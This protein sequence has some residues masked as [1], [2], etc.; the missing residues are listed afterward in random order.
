MAQPTYE[1]SGVCYTATSGQTTFAL[2]STDGHPIG[3]LS[4]N[5]IHIRTSA[6]SGETW[7]ILPVNTGWTFADPA[8]SIVLVTPATAGE[9]IDIRRKTPIDED[10]VDFQAGSL[11]TAGQLNDAETFSLYC[12][13]ELADDVHN[14]TPPEVGL[15]TTDDLPEGEVNLYYTDERVAEYIAE[16]PSGLGVTKII[17]GTN[18]TLTPS[19]GEGVVTINSTGGG[20]SGGVV[21]K[22]LVDVTQPAPANPQEGDLWANTTEGVADASWI[23]IAGETVGVGDEPI[24]NGTEWQVFPRPP[25]VGAVESVNGQTGIVSLGVEEL[26]DF[27]YYPSSNLVT[28]LG[29]QVSTS[30]LPQGTEFSGEPSQGG[31]YFRFRK[32]TNLP[33][34]H[35]VSQLSSGDQIELTWNNVGTMRTDS[36]SFVG[37]TESLQ[38]NGYTLCLMT[39]QS[40]LGTMSTGDYFLSVYSPLITN[41]EEPIRSGQ[42]LIYDQTTEKWRPQLPALKVE[43]LADF[44]YYPASNQVTL[45]GP[46]VGDLSAPGVTDNAYKAYLGGSTNELWVLYLASNTAQNE[47]FEQLT[48]GDAMNIKYYVNANGDIA[49]VEVACTFK[50]F[51]PNTNSNPLQSWLKLAGSFTSFDTALGNYSMVITS[52]NISNG[53]EPITTGQ[54]LIFDRTTESWR[55]EDIATEL[56]ISALPALP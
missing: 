48:V 46:S 22:G 5:H 3:Y 34:Y 24:Y 12:D 14:L 20:G 47:V 55:P 2:T 33:F 13:Q 4:P 8:T 23:G 1:Y 52:P 45:I 50:S 28:L 30:V 32:E 16:N 38:G 9:W 29:P 26:D 36:V 11:L 31:S 49:T 27:A 7:N 44:A 10:W 56:N 35:G 18:I 17:P 19:T 15:A 6:D 54:A 42:T 37:V 21:Y 41:G 43:E 25:I 39:V 51:G 40:V 53:F